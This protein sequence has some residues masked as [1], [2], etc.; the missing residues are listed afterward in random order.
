VKARYKVTTTHKKE[1]AMSI[2]KILRI[3]LH[4]SL[5]T[6]PTAQMELYAAASAFGWI[7]SP[8]SS[9]SEPCSDV[10]DTSSIV[11]L[12]PAD[13]PGQ[14]LIITGTVYKSDGKTPLAG[15]VIYAY[16]TDASGV[17]SRGT[18][19]SR[20]PRLKG[21]LKTRADGRYEIRTIKPGSYP[22]SRNPAHIHA[23]IT[24]PGRKE[25]WI[26]EFLFDGDPFLKKDDFEK[27]GNKGKF[28][29]IL[30]VQMGK[31]GVLQAVR[32]I[33]VDVP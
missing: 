28:S 9:N 33:T 21:W 3:F 4:A 22:G 7:F 5:L 11:T 19:S 27:F 18:N 32:D 30:K 24:A 20:N 26:D 15:A 31:G 16:Q 17:Y 12:A 2:K 14:R 6:I 13:E 8:S 10:S 29:S 1:A 25:Q 23:S